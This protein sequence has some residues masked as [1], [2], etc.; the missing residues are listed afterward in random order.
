MNEHF[1][2]KENHGSG[3]LAG[4]TRHLIQFVEQAGDRQTVL[5]VFVDPAPRKAV[6]VQT[7]VNAVGIASKDSADTGMDIITFPGNPNDADGPGILEAI[8]NWV[9]AAH[10]L[11]LAPPITITLHGAQIVWHAAR[12]GILAAPDRMETLLLALVDFGFHEKEL[13]QLERSIAESWSQLETDA[14]L[15]FEVTTRD[16]QRMESVA[17]QAQRILSVRMRHAR[18]VPRLLRPGTH[19]STQANQ[20][21]ERLRERTRI[22]DRLEAVASQLEAFERVYEMASQRFAEFRITKH[23]TTLEWAIIV[24]LATETLLLLIDVL[25]HLER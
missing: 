2:A 15:A 10:G 22:E 14:P 9:L 19:L 6:T 5:M 13:S 24:L 16:M 23:E 8:M 17:R 11:G 20:L 7:D 18:L 1:S 3:P 21:G 12:V 4:A 25:L